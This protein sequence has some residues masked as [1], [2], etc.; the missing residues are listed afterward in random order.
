MASQ[1]DIQDLAVRISERRSRSR[2]FPISR[3]ALWGAA[4]LGV[5]TAALL[6]FVRGSSEPTK[7][8]TAEVTRG[9]IVQTV[10]STGTLN[11][12]ISVPVGSY[13]S[14]PI[15]AIYT[16]YNSVVKRGQLIAKIDPQ[17]F[18]LKVEGT[19]AQLANSKTQLFKDRADMHYKKLLYE[20]NRGLLMLGAASQNTVDNDFSIYQQALAQIS[21]DQ[22]T[23]RLQ[24][25]VLK[26][27]EVNLNYTNIVSPVEGTVVSRNVDVGQTVAS[28][29]QTPTLF[30]IARDLTRM[31]VD[32]NVS[33]SDIGGVREGASTSWTWGR[34]APPDRSAARGIAS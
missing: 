21:L 31:Q 33:E 5:L 13:V 3:N 2:I 29:F 9:P 26:D 32:C 19:R 34:R 1:V 12:V 25:S 7:Y 27:A 4:A 22:G 30:L 14:G 10:T 11:P 17:P 6:Y 24:E 16:D 18:E 8:I 20:R 15:I 23:I 28:S